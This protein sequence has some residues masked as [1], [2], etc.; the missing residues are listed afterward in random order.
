MRYLISCSN[1]RALLSF[2]QKGV[3]LHNCS[4][5]CSNSRRVNIW[6]S[7]C[8]YW[9]RVKSYRMDKCN[10]WTM[11]WRN[12]DFYKVKLEVSKVTYRS[13]EIYL[14]EWIY[15]AV[16]SKLTTRGFLVSRWFSDCAQTDRSPSDPRV[17]R[18]P[19]D[20]D[21][22]ME[23]QLAAVVDKDRTCERS[24]LDQKWM[25]PSTWPVITA[26]QARPK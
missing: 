18:T 2:V 20:S 26:L 3:S 9:W 4:I 19:P 15:Q 24:M 6:M 7:V 8:F 21:N 25:E 5:F 17:N 10:F 13:I 11:G 16:F 14:Q 22:A 23:M 12:R 1:F